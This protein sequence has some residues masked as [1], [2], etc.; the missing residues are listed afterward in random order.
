MNRWNLPDLGVGIG[1]RTTHFGQILGQR[2][3]VDWFEVLSENFLRTGGRPLYVLD[4]VAE[5]Y[6]VVLHG[7]SLSIGSTAPL[8]LDYL[9]EL[10]ALARRTR[11]HWVSDHLCWTGVLGRNTHDLLP[12]PYTEEALRHVVGRLRQVSDFMERPFVL[13]NPSSY[14]EFA[15]STM[16]EWEFLARMSEEADCG[17]LLDV[18]NVY[19]SSYNHGFDPNVYVDAIPADRVVQYHVAGHTNKGTHI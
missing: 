13:E 2:P 3:A 6:P 7:V 8:D 15:D 11:A 4:Q 1:L 16:P 12:M 5:R 9:G 17:L 19:V 18:N 14:V 10:K